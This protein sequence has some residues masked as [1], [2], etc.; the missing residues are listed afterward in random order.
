MAKKSSKKRSNKPK[1]ARAASAEREGA[2]EAK[3]LPKAAAAAPPAT[4]DVMWLTSE[5]LF[6]AGLTFFG[7]V[8]GRGLA[9]SVVQALGSV[10]PLVIGG[11]WGVGTGGMVGLAQWL[12]LK[13]NHDAP[14][15]WLLFTPSATPSPA[16]QPRRG[17]CHCTPRPSR[18]SRG[19]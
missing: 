16:P 18:P 15:G 13:R 12:H 19:R 6:F 7:E 1:P 8:L 17:H 14:W 4:L 2:G 9:P 10:D 3:A 11:A 5:V